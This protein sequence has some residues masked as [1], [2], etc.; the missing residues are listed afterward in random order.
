MYRNTVSHES[1]S[2]L[3]GCIC[4]TVKIDR[5]KCF[6]PE[7]WRKAGPFF[8]RPSV[9]PLCRKVASEFLGTFILIFA[10][11]ATPIV[12]EKTGGKVTLVGLAAS[13]GLVVTIVIF[14]TGHI[15]GA[16]INPAVTIAFAAF[17]HFPWTQ[18]PVYIVAQVMGSICAAF[19]LKGIFHPF[20]NGGVTVPSGSYSQAFCLELIITFILMFVVTAVST[21]KRAVGKLAGIVVGATVILN[22][23][24]AGPYTGASMNP[25]RTLGPALAS[26]NYK[27]IWVYILAPITGALLGAFAYTAIGANGTPDE[28]R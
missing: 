25:V 4:F 9:I 7:V 2:K 24:I 28:E 8:Q 17:H 13:A 26:G 27:A 5:C 6:P 20:M 16:H 23:F 21:D 11:A 18:V 19:A 1:P 22:N 3:D 10:A 14:S 15:S 12:N